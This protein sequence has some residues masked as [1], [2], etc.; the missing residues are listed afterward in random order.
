MQ[1]DQNYTL[2]AKVAC[3]EDL[4]HEFKDVSLRSLKDCFAKY[5]TG[6]LNSCGGTIYFG[7]NDLGVVRGI[8]LCWQ[9]RDDLRQYIANQ[10]GTLS[11]VTPTLYEIHFCEVYGPRKRKRCFWPSCKTAGDVPVTDLYVVEISVPA[12]S[13]CGTNMYSVP[14]RQ[15]GNPVRACWQRSHGQ[16]ELMPE[17]ELSRRG[18]TKQQLTDQKK[19]SGWNRD[20]RISLQIGVGSLKAKAPAGGRGGG[21]GGGG[22][23]GRRRWA[24]KGPRTVAPAP[25]PVALVPLEL[26]ALE[27]NMLELLRDH[28]KDGV[29]QDRLPALYDGK[30][31]TTAVGFEE[32][33]RHLNCTQAK[34]LMAKMRAVATPH[35]SATT[36]SAVCY[37]EAGW[38]PP[39]RIVKAS[40]SYPSERGTSYGPA[41]V[42][43]PN[44][45]AV[46]HTNTSGPPWADTSA[47][48]YVAFDFGDGHE[49]RVTG[50]RLTQQLEQ[51]S[52]G[53]GRPARWL[54]AE[55][56]DFALEAAGSLDGP[57][58]EMF[59]GAAT[60]ERAPQT[61]D[62]LCTSQ[63]ARFWRVFVFS[64]H[65]YGHITL[66]GIQ[67]RG[68][69]VDVPMP[70]AVV[71][72]PAPAPAAPEP[73]ADPVATAAPPADQWRAGLEG[74]RVRVHHTPPRFGLGWLGEGCDKPLEG[75]V[76]GFK[77]GRFLGF[78]ASRHSVR[79]DD[80]RVEEVLLDRNGNGGL[81][82]EVV[83][84]ALAA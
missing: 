2:G 30:F 14:Y 61:F 41:N 62:R 33:K 6:F 26:A 65:G 82:F 21:G 51:N 48:E 47:S 53:R 79:F 54:G 38:L 29:P 49:C 13:A 3:E 76:Q 83:S 40:S 17:A 77:Q 23:G 15:I 46:W 75:T 8:E 42:L 68:E 43:D 72:E 81:K 18:A 31:S 50:V 69:V 22:G 74:R 78:G 9:D 45:D 59:R 67:F 84:W 11:Q 10:M 39:P 28:V 73:V 64:S 19:L 34:Q 35:G 70:A 27:Q 5:S 80:G 56:K 24:R 58:V 71:V 60:Q 37:R 7:V 52:G 55:V 32:Q 66:R 36:G 1:D 25:T 20:T 4:T 57:W 44:S 63:Q 16:I 12:S